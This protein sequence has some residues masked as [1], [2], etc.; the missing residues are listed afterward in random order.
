MPVD[1]ELISSENFNIKFKNYLR[2]FYIYQFKE[3]GSD[4]KIRGTN[5]KSDLNKDIID[6][7]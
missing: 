6:G 2:D 5:D 3:R 4:F 7:T 1:A